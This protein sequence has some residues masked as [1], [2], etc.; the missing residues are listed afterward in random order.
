MKNQ[1]QKKTKSGSANFGSKALLYTAGLI[2]LALA[3]LLFSSY[4]LPRVQ[5]IESMREGAIAPFPRPINP[6]LGA[7]LGSFFALRIVLSG[8]NILLLVYL[9]H[10][11]VKD[12]VQLRTSFALGLV[13]FLFSFLIYALA[14]F[15][16]I[17]FLSGIRGASAVF[18]FIPLLFSALGLVIFAKLSN[19]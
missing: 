15:P 3:I 8:I 17:H 6:A 5:F 14:S 10:V 9:L 2:A 13:A 1:K 7:E 4:F 18:S 11:Y 16:P 19:E 12:Y